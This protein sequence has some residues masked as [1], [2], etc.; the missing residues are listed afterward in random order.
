MKKKVSVRTHTVE[1]KR[2]LD[3]L[4]LGLIDETMKYV[5]GQVGAQVIYNLLESNSHLKREEISEKTDV[6]SAGLK[7]LLGSGAPVVEKMILKKLYCKLE[8]KFEEKK[9]HEFS[10]YIKELTRP[11]EKEQKCCMH[12][13]E[14]TQLAKNTYNAEK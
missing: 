6:F 7:R 12:L 2:T 13:D 3:D 9:G 8:L 5:F 4:L 14:L 1:K 10:D 11:R